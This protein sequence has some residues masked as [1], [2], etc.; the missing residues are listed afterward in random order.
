M[1]DWN[2]YRSHAEETSRAATAGSPQAIALFRVA[3]PYFVTVNKAA[4]TLRVKQ[5]QAIDALV[6]EAKDNYQTSQWIV[7]GTVIGVA[8]LT[9]TMLMLL[10]RLI[11]RPV[12]AMSGLL[13]K[14]AAGERSVAIPAND[15][16]DEVGD[17][18][19][20]A[21]ALRDQLAQA[22]RQKDE[23]A[24]LIVS[25]IGTGM[26]ALAA[27]DL[28]ARIDVALDGP[29]A[30][31]AS[32]FNHA[33]TQVE[34][35]MVAVRGVSEG[36]RAASGEIRSASRTCRS[37]PSSRPPAWRKPPPR[38]TRSPIWWDAPPPTRNAP[39]RSRRTPAARRRAA[40][41]SCVK[42]WPR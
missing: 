13:G 36:L 5:S 15:A 25:T 22:D 10:V 41:R 31:L 2:E 40:G 28:T 16:R 27:G 29:F 42:R 9:M 6:A 23:Q 30:S 11:A 26:Q 12:G 32:D 34:Q 39:T 38:C 17:M 37:G 8:V 14:L 3:R 21:A 7:I 24:A 20:A 1:R 19:R 33:M 35:A 18:M 4:D